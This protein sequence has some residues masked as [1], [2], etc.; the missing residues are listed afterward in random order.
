[1]AAKG[2][3]AMSAHRWQGMLRNLLVAL[4]VALAASTFL[5]APYN[6]AVE[7]SIMVL[8]IATVVLLAK[9]RCPGCGARVRRLG[10][11]PN[12]FRPVRDCPDCGKDLTVAPAR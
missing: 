9:V 7:I 6:L 12:I 10:R 5:P 3:G 2:L 4:L 8:F 11:D 1:M